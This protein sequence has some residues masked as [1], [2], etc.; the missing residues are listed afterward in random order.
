MPCPIDSRSPLYQQGQ[1]PRERIC[2]FEHESY[3]HLVAHLFIVV[4]PF[5]FSQIYIIKASTRVDTNTTPN[6]L[7]IKIQLRDISDKLIATTLGS[8]PVNSK[9]RHSM[10]TN[11]ANCALAS[12]VYACGGEAFSNFAE[13]SRLHVPQRQTK[14]AVLPFPPL[15][16][17]SSWNQQS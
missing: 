4:H 10:I 2:Q 15:T 14:C 8:N 12:A 17:R 7:V 3:I 6:S 1:Q 16:S 9:P 13:L 11:G 5:S